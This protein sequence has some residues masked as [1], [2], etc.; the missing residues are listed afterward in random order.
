MP[1]AAPIHGRENRVTRAVIAFR[2]VRTARAI[3][4]QMSDHAHHD[5]P[6]GLTNPILLTD[7]WTRQLAHQ[8]RSALFRVL[9][10]ESWFCY[11]SSSYCIYRWGHNLEVSKLLIVIRTARWP[12]QRRTGAVAARNGLS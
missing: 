5:V 3:V 4:M 8:Q 7:G 11:S 9:R 10:P 12:Q 2:D 1:L 6:T